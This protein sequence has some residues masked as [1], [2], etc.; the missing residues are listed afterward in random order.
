M[1]GKQVHSVCSVGGDQDLVPS[2]PQQHL[3]TFKS[4][5]L[6]IDAQDYGSSRH[7]TPPIFA[8]QACEEPVFCAVPEAAPLWREHDLCQTH[9]ARQGRALG[10]QGPWGCKHYLVTTETRM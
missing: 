5:P 3:A 1:G 7:G 8:R 2:F 4:I 9:K 6:V 10:L